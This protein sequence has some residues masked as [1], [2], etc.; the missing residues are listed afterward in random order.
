MMFGSDLSESV[1]LVQ[2]HTG[3]HSLLFK[4]MR[5]YVPISSSCVLVLLMAFVL[6]CFPFSMGQ[7]SAGSRWTGSSLASSRSSTNSFFTSTASPTWRWW[8][9]TLTSTGTCC[10]LTTTTTSARQCPRLILC[11]GSSYN[12]KV[13]CQR[14]NQDFRWL[15]LTINLF[16]QQEL[17]FSLSL[18]MLIRWFISPGLLS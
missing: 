18:K 13:G 6:F 15:L 1:R 5:S 7:S 8:L 12:D 3:F 4:C 14:C 11:S 10:R 2:N 16:S 17:K 9:A